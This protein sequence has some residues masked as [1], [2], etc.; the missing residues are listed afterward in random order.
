ML[1]ALISPANVGYTFP[2]HIPQI[3]GE[4]RLFLPQVIRSQRGEGSSRLWGGEPYEPMDVM[5]S[6]ELIDMSRSLWLFQSKRCSVFSHVFSPSHCREYKYCLPPLRS[7]RPKTSL[8]N[9]ALFFMKVS[10]IDYLTNYY[11]ALSDGLL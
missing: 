10:T 7:K 11:L 6:Q 8:V 3:L 4:T 1:F 9:Y 5:T 2:R